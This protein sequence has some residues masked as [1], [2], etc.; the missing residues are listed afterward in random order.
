M[1]LEA[2]GQVGGFEAYLGGTAAEM[3]RTKSQA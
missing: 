3:G 1:G 2:G